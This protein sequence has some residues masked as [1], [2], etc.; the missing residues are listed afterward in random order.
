MA[1]Y[2]VRHGETNGNAN[3]IVQTPDTPLSKTGYQQ[4]QQFAN[5]YADFPISGIVSSDY[6]RAQSTAIA[7]HRKNNASYVTNILLRERNF[8]DLRGHA[9]ASIPDDIMAHDY[10]PPNGE[11][12]AEFTH[13]VGEAWKQIIALA[14]DETDDLL[15][16][17][18]GLVLR[19]IFTDILSLSTHDLLQTDI[20][21]TCVT[22]LNGPCYTKIELLCNVSHLKQ[23]ALEGRE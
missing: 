5:A 21:N 16:M 4:A 2:L 20:Q 11:S 1:I 8:G 9:Y 3:K 6:T 12:Y 7:L 14:Q 23:K 22:R 15:V 19:C 13:R 18:H 10:H 17:S